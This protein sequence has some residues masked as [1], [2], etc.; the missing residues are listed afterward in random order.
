MPLLV[1]VS[2]G[3]RVGDDEV[4]TDLLSVT[5][6]DEVTEDVPE[7]L[8]VVVALRDAVLVAERVDV[9]D[10][11]VVCTRDGDTLN[12]A[13]T[14]SDFEIDVTTDSE[15][16]DVRVGV[17]VLFTVEDIVGVG[18][19]DRLFEGDSELLLTAVGD[20]VNDD[21]SVKHKSVSGLQRPLCSTHHWHSGAA[22]HFADPRGVS[23]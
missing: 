6:T 9:R 15:K 19:L 1:A 7:G 16:E 5:E 10:T 21:V 2:L 12:V 23:E 8:I 13:L 4:L 17:C 3:D 14:V 11:V 22:L 20:V 18:M